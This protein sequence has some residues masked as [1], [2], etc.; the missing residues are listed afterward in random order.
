[1]FFLHNIK[2]M[3]ITNP[4]SDVHCLYLPVYNDDYHWQFENV[5]KKVTDWLQ[6]TISQPGLLKRFSRSFLSTVCRDPRTGR[7]KARVLQ[8]ISP[9]NTVLL[10]M[11]D[12]TSLTWRIALAIAGISGHDGMPS[13]LHDNCQSLPSVSMV[14]G[15]TRTIIMAHY[16]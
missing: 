2:N 8:D 6:R 13:S 9:C 3:R 16:L 14:I 10:G 4:I 7:V 1:M 12:G 5:Y 15:L 11:R